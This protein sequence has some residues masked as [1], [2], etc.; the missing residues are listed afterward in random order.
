[1]HCVSMNA[2]SK[3][4]E[5]QWAEVTTGPSIQ[6]VCMTSSKETSTG[7]K[8]AREYSKNSKTWIR[9]NLPQREHD[10]AAARNS[11]SHQKLHLLPR[12]HTVCKLHSSCNSSN[13]LLLSLPLLSEDSSTS[14]AL[15]SPQVTTI[16][17]VSI[18]PRSAL[19]TATLPHTFQQDKMD[20]AQVTSS[21]L[22]AL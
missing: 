17:Q 15:V 16:P 12:P 4:P 20:T 11:R 6:H 19:H 13:T 10:S 2:S 14:H 9:S 21:H 22:P 1:M 3:L 7:D 18:L 5:H 8:H